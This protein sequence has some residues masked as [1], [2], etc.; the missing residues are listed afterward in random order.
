MELK[1][2]FDFPKPE[3]YEEIFGDW[4]KNPSSLNEKFNNAKPYPFIKINN[5]LKTEL[6]EK[7]LKQFPTP[8]NNKWN[9]YKNPVEIKFALDKIDEMPSGFSFVLEALSNSKVAEKLTELTGIEKLEHDPTLHGAGINCHKPGGKLLIHLD[10]ERHPILF[11]PR[12]RR[13][14]LIL[15][16]NKNWKS[17]YNGGLEL[18]E[19][20]MS[21]CTETIYPEFNCG[22]IFRTNRK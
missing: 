9:I 13:L 14:N 18:W 12:E 5:F 22:V 19:P 17:E 20:N 11:P 15:F 6:A 10:Y 7:L 4:I 21:K 2:D 8:D 3:N 1:T 16:F